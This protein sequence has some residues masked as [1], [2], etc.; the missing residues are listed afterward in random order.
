MWRS[1]AKTI[2]LS[3]RCKRRNKAKTDN[4]VKYSVV[5]IVNKRPYYFNDRSRALRT[6]KVVEMMTKKTAWCLFN[7]CR[8][9]QYCLSKS[10]VCLRHTCD[11]HMK[12]AFLSAP[13]T[14]YRVCV[15]TNH[16]DSLMEIFSLKSVF[17]CFV[18]VKSNCIVPNTLKDSTGN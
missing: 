13:I 3:N 6:K 1:G 18:F 17:P 14:T 16:P 2:G 12:L 7:F 11:F 10:G 15:C 4:Y 5:G 8:L 9:C